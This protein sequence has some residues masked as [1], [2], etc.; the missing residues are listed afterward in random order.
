MIKLYTQLLEEM[1]ARFYANNGARRSGEPGLLNRTPRTK[2]EEYD[3][4]KVSSQKFFFGYNYILMFLL[5]R[6][7]S[8]MYVYNLKRNNSLLYLGGTTLHYVI[9][10]KC[11]IPPFDPHLPPGLGDNARF[12]IASLENDYVRERDRHTLLLSRILHAFTIL[13]L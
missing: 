4:L 11:R 12:W 7:K 6:N 2:E 3:L 13:L 9:I 1:T 5:H 8:T 10:V